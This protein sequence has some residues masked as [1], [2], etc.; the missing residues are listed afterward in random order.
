M[1]PQFEP[2][3]TVQFTFVSSIAPDAAPTFKVLNAANTAV[4][5]ITA[6]TSDST[7]YY[8][9]YTMPTTQGAYVGEWV[10]AKTVAG[11]AYN[12]VKRFVFN[13]RLTE[14]PT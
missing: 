14:E 10:A 1:R 3:N 12:F 9:M 11:S 2:G 7:N 5:S 4:A 6:A 13:I 8:A